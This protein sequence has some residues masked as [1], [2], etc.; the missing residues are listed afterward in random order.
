M[1]VTSPARFVSL[2]LLAS[3]CARPT[4]TSRPSLQ[5]KLLAKQK[6]GKKRLRERSIGN[7]SLP[8]TA[9]YTVLGGVEGKRKGH[10]KDAAKDKRK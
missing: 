1:V 9:F 7:V 8:M 10:A 6:E 4:L 3:P 5:L 2:S